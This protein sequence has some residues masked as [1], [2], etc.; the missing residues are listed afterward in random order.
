M[1][2]C[3]FPR[4]RIDPQTSGIDSDGLKNSAVIWQNPLSPLLH[5][6]RKSSFSFQVFLEMFLIID[7]LIF[8]LIKVLDHKSLMIKF[9]VNNFNQWMYKQRVSSAFDFYSILDSSLM[10]IISI[11][12][13]INSA[14]VPRSIFIQFWIQRNYLLRHYYYCF[15][16]LH[17]IFSLVKGKFLRN[18]LNF[19]YDVITK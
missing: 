6:S 14:W 2:L 7:F 12:E 11:N 9:N 18:A 8:G 16:F 17:T 4:P 19:V 3:R 5:F 15:I 10:S 1:I 13:C